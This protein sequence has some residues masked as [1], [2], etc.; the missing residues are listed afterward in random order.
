[1]LYGAKAHR[2][3]T[4]MEVLVAAG[5]GSMLL[6]ALVSLLIPAMKL[7]ERGTRLVALDQ[8]AILLE[9]RVERALK[10]TCR[11][12]AHFFS[13]ANGSHLSTH[14]IQGALAHSQPRLG[15]DLVVFSLANEQLRERRVPLTSTPQSATILPDAVLLEALPEATVTYQVDGVKVFEAEVGVG[16]QVDLHYTLEK[17]DQSL[18]VRQTVFLTNS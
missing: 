13:D 3:F 16:P 1:M 17:G 8:R 6:Y 15:P 9:Q 11:R 2:G 18:E 14:P 10:A 5:L 4:L 7:S 12:G